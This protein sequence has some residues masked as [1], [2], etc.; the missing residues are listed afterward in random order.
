M[1]REMSRLMNAKRQKGNDISLSFSPISN[2][3]DIQF[4]IEENPFHGLI[5][6]W[7]K[8]YAMLQKVEKKEKRKKGEGVTNFIG[9]FNLHLDSKD[10]SY[11][12]CHLLLFLAFSFS[13]RVG[14]RN[15][16]R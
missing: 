14:N 4:L 12:T 2:K 11:H 7:G 8:Y 6:I 16:P 10:T 3:N 13:N 15:H 9:L 1:V 5:P